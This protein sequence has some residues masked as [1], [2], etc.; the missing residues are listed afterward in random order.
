MQTLFTKIE[1][2]FPPDLVTRELGA[3]AYNFLRQAIT[4]T[5]PENVLA[6]DF[7]NVRVMDSSFAGGSILKLLRELVDGRFGEKY[8]VLTGTSESTE[9]NIDATINGHGLK[10]GLQVIDETGH[11]LLG[12]IEPNLIRTLALVN[13]R[14]TMTAREL[15]DLETGMA[16]NTA[17][18]R[19]KKLFDL[20]LVQRRE[21]TIETGRQHVYHAIHI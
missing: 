8:M 7:A 12:Q 11:R 3:Q 6:L 9:Y 5:R 1:D 2:L 19:L 18:N 10:L 16:I 14:K 20:H 15:A 17:S 13:D 4:D 21:E